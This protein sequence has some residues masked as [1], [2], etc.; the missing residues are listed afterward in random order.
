METPP[1][2]PLLPQSSPPIQA[3]RGMGCFA[4]GCLSAI[5]ILVL[6][7]IVGAGGGWFVYSKAVNAFT[8]DQPA[9]V[10]IEEPT[11]TQLHAANAAIARLREATMGNEKATVEFSETDVN[12]LIAHDPAFARMRGKTRIKIDDSIVTVEMSAPLDRIPLPKLKGRWFNGIVRLRFSYMDNE[13]VF[14]G[15][16]AIANGHDLD[17]SGAF[18]SSFNR[19]FNQSFN[20]GFHRGLE[21]DRQGT[22]FWKHIKSITVEKSRLVVETRQ[23]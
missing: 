14:D 3:K 12:T 4:I 11:D 2:S 22:T 7:L 10:A 9:N 21:Q 17:L 23:L 20:D 18:F 5:I 15:Q 8:S 1:P 13:F 16:S 19:S 6:L